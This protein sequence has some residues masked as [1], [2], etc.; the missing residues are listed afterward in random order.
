MLAPVITLTR[1]FLHSLHQVTAWFQKNQHPLTLTTFA[2]A[3]LCVCDDYP[4]MEEDILQSLPLVIRITIHRSLLNHRRDLES[5]QGLW[6]QFAQSQIQHCGFCSFHR[7]GWPQSNSPS[8]SNRCSCNE[9]FPSPVRSTGEIPHRIL[10]LLGREDFVANQTGRPPTK[11]RYQLTDTCLLGTFPNLAQAFR[12]YLPEEQ[13]CNVNVEY[14]SENLSAN[15]STSSKL[16]LDDQDGLLNVEKSSHSRF[17][18]D[19]RMHEVRRVL[20]FYFTS[21]PAGVSFVALL[22]NYLPES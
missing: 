13:D 17:S 10:I 8:H 6:I 21:L 4:G 3:F 16:S 2:I 12:G 14:H 1:N 5:L 20:F 15:H 18:E 22:Q 11:D 9:I 19:E 7:S